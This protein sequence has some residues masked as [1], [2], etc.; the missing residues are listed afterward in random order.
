MKKYP[1]YI[2][3]IIILLVII[4]CQPTPPPIDPISIQNTTVAIGNTAVAMA[5]TGVAQT[6]SV[7]LAATVNAQGTQIAI[8][9]QPTATWP[10]PIPPFVVTPL[11]DNSIQLALLAK[12]G[13]SESDTTLFSLQHND[14]QLAIGII[15]STNKAE[16]VLWMAQ[17]DGNGQWGIIYISHG[18]TPPCEEL[19][20]LNINGSQLPLQCL[21]TNG[22]QTMLGEWLRQ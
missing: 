13:W 19:Q 10:P 2:P 8:L 5:W 22:N 1:F 18:L 14:G 20:K 7:G 17:K 4:G 3:L 16:D 11:S 6:Q 15:H 9:N 21:D 12:F